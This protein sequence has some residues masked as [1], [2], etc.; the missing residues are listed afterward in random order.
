MRSSSRLTDLAFASQVHHTDALT[1]YQRVR[2]A[3][4][5]LT[6]AL[7]S[8]DMAAQSMPDSSPAQWPQRPGTWLFE[9]VPDRVDASG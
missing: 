1:R 8:E 9:T 4:V 5:A 6:R 2:H 7:T 3:T